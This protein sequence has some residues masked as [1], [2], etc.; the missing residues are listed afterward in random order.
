LE[1]SLDGTGLA[2]E[3]TGTTVRVYRPAAA[4]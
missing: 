2:F 1:R 4:D 3:I